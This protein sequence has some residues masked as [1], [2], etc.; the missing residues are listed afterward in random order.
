RRS[1][2][3]FLDFFFLV[4]LPHPPIVWHA[5]RGGIVAPL[6]ILR[7]LPYVALGVPD[8]ARP[9]GSEVVDPGFHPGFPGPPTRPDPLSVGRPDPVEPGRP[10]VV[11][12]R[13]PDLTDGRSPERG[14]RVAGGVRGER[15]AGR[16]PRRPARGGRRDRDRPE[17][18]ALRVLG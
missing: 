2:Q 10:G 1:G 17:P 14:P 7:R 3:A 8:P 18:R 5:V 15:G 11:V 6:P 13:R 12:V 4:A 9:Y 16:L